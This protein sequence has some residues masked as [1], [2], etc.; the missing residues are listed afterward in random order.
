MFQESMPQN[1]TCQLISEAWLPMRNR[2]TQLWAYNSERKKTHNGA[3]Y[4]RDFLSGNA[5]EP[6]WSERNNSHFSTPGI[7]GPKKAQNKI[8]WFSFLN[9]GRVRIKRIWQIMILGPLQTTNRIQH[10]KDQIKVSWYEICE[11]DPAKTYRVHC[12]YVSHE[13]RL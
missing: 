10:S 8:C 3:E 7:K 13:W 6:K 1:G 5:R 11:R 9:L 2:I 4:C 12:L